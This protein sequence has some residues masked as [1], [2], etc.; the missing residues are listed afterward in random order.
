MTNIKCFSWFAVNT[1]AAEVL[2][3]TAGDWAEVTEDS[4]LLDVCCGTGTIGLSL[5]QVS[6]IMGQLDYH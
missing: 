1:K 4:V 2:Y 6:I 5:A 3:Q